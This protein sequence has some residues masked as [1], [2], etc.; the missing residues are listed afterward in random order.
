[1]QHQWSLPAGMIRSHATSL[2]T[3]ISASTAGS[4]MYPRMTSIPGS[5]GATTGVN[6]LHGDDVDDANNTTARIAVLLKPLAG[7][8]NHTEPINSYVSGML[9]LFNTRNTRP[10]M[11]QTTHVAPTVPAF[12]L[13]LVNFWLYLAAQHAHELRNAQTLAAIGGLGRPQATKSVRGGGDYRGLDSIANVFYGCDDREEPF[14]WITVANVRRAFPVA[15]GALHLLSNQAGI[16]PVPYSS[17]VVPTSVNVG[18]VFETFNKFSGRAQTGARAWLVLTRIPKEDVYATTN[19]PVTP[20]NMAVG[21]ALSSAPHRFL[22]F[23]L[24]TW[25]GTGTDTPC[26]FRATSLAGPWDPASA[27]SPLGFVAIGTDD[28]QD[29]TRWHGVAHTE[30]VSIPFGTDRISVHVFTPGHVISLGRFARVKNSYRPHT[31]SEISAAH[32]LNQGM[33]DP[34]NA[35]PTCELVML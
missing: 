34:T 29:A 17:G 7:P 11:R 26:R 23:R 4:L 2:P 28:N 31:A 6:K 1:M 25:A 27:S 9:V 30:H 19:H 32:I 13:P 3:S 8:G 33:V 12:S 20:E 15:M 24:V 21:K 5:I 22:Q 35:S 16:T 14:S 18:G 10:T